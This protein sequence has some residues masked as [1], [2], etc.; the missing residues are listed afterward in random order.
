[1]SVV[2]EQMIAPIHV[3]ILLEPILV[4]VVPDIYWGLMGLPV[5]VSTN[6]FII[7][8]INL[9]IHTNIHAYLLAKHIN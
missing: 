7:V 9:H 4:D 2:Q 8:I 1:M 5:M 6:L 3:Q